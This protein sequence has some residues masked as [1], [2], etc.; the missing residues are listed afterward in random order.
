M[1]ITTFRANV[2]RIHSGR[3]GQ[4]RLPKEEATKIITGKKFLRVKWKN[5]NHGKNMAILE[6]TSTGATLYRLNLPTDLFR[7]LKLKGGDLLLCNL[8]KDKNTLEIRLCDLT[9]SV[10]YNTQEDITNNTQED[11]QP[12]ATTVKGINL[13]Y[14]IITSEELSIEKTLEQIKPFLYTT[15]EELVKNINKIINTPVVNL[16]F[17][18]QQLYCRLFYIK[19]SLEKYGYIG[20]NITSEYSF[21]VT[22]GEEIGEIKLEFK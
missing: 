16:S 13:K 6:H 12:L 19:K 2:W 11:T 8:D 17:N 21:N 4:I 9:T 3:S 18:N 10:I 1:N 15:A 14:E 7:D 5:N 22:I 20:L